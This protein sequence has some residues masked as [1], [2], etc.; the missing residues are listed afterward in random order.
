M[1]ARGECKW[2]THGSKLGSCRWQKSGSFC[3]HVKFSFTSHMAHL[4]GLWNEKKDRLCLL[5]PPLPLPPQPP[6]PPPTALQHHQEICILNA[7]VNQPRVTV[8]IGDLVR[9]AVSTPTPREECILA[10]FMRG[11]IN[12]RHAIVRRS[13]TR[14]LIH[15][16]QDSMWAHTHAA[17]FLIAILPA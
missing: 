14:T 17:Q 3:L 4:T 8:W 13:V 7:G 11:W 16:I 12:S 1:L 2:G 5:Q 6:P 9:D 10:H 15:I